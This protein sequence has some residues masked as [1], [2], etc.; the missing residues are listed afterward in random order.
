M[1][2]NSSD[3]DAKD[4]DTFAAD[5]HNAWRRYTNLFG[6]VPHGTMPQIKAMLALT[7]AYRA[8]GEVVT[9]NEPATV[10]PCLSLPLHIA[11]LIRKV[12]LPTNP[13]KMRTAHPDTLAAVNHYIDAL[14]N[15]E[16][17][18]LVLAPQSAKPGVE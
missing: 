17:S 8:P 18:A 4:F 1:S 2:K 13:R 7:A 16:C 11:Q 10:E 15:L 3:Y 12:F 9:R 5:L 6:E 14:N